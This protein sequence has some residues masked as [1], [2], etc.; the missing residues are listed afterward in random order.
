M[1]A[2]HRWAPIIHAWANGKAVQFKDTSSRWLDA[3]GLH[4]CAPS[5]VP[6]L[7][8]RIKPEVVRYRVALFKTGSNFFYTLT[9]DEAFND[10]KLEQRPS[11]VRW[12]GDWQ[13]VEA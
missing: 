12:L 8:W 4:G 2:P 10:K 11:F 6:E 3:N 1:S 13:E 7:E 5:F 9:T